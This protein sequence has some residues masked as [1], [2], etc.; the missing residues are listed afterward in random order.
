[1]LSHSFLYFP[2][3]EFWHGIVPRFFPRVWYDNDV[4]YLDTYLDTNKS[5]WA[6]IVELNIV[7]H[8]FSYSAWHL[9][10]VYLKG[11]EVVAELFSYN[12]IITNMHLVHEAAAD[13]WSWSWSL[14]FPSPPLPLLF[15]SDV[16]SGGLWRQRDSTQL[17][18]P[19]LTLPP[20]SSPIIILVRPSMQS[21]SGP[22]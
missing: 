16:G 2:Y 15:S 20:S 4:A 11:E 5:K 6:T 19:P 13:L 7:W 3:Y 1:M 10:E 9:T 14:Y 8:T 17:A 22:P 21:L 12:T 18:S